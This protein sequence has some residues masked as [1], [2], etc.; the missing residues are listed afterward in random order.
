MPDY[1]PSIMDPEMVLE[2]LRN[3]L[4]FSEL[5]E[6][7][8]RELA[9]GCT[10]DFHPK[11]TLLYEQGVT[12]VSC[13]MLIQKGGVR[14]FTRD[15]QGKENLVDFRGEGD[16]LGGLAMLQGGRAK[17][18]ATTV[19]DTFFIRLSR[20][21]F[22]N[23]L[24]KRPQVAQFYSKVLSEQYVTK[25]FDSLRNRKELLLGESGLSL[26]RAQVGEMLHRP[27]VTA[28]MGR[29]IQEAAQL[30]VRHGIGSL[31]IT[32]PSGEILGIVTDKDLRKTISVG[33]DCNAP[34]ETIMSS[35]VQAVEHR[36]LCFDA[37]LQMMT[38]HIH[39]L[40][41]KREG[42]VIG[43]VTSHDIMVMQ[44]KSPMSL[45]RE[46]MTQR[47]FEGLYPLSGRIPQVVRSLV[48][49]GAKA[50][51]IAR[52]IT[53]INDMIV[54]KVL[55]LLLAQLGPP[56][57]P[58]CWLL[59]GSEGRKEQ[60]FFTD[61]DNA[62]VYRDPG[63]EILQRAADVYFQAFTE[64]ANGHLIK[65]GMPPCPGGIMASNPK[66]RQPFAVWR[67][68][69]ERWIAVNNPQE[70]M[71]AAIFFDFRPCF[72]E[73]AYAEE[74]RSHVTTHARRQDV[75]LRHL[76]AN[77]LETRPPLSFFRN[78]IVE[79]DGEHKN[80]LDIKT[81]GIAPL[82]DFIRVLAL[83]HG[84]RETNTLGRL[85]LLLQAQALPMELAK[86]TREA[87]E[88]MLQLRLVHQLETVERG[89]VPDNH[90]A[91]DSLSELERKTL[92]EAF[93]LIGRAQTHLKE[94][95]RMNIA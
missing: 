17:F 35:P 77:C 84:I 81:R 63:D 46:I 27:P 34:I 42:E 25:A 48:E 33:M 50:G 74:L 52:M 62:L 55:A 69:F 36:D 75:F 26:F 19:E 67:D 38:R 30:M 29:T 76:A 90:I 68:Y 10:I 41:V 39:H 57:V 58:F 89:G 93:A 5:S 95:F 64:R 15:D 16:A 6:A 8:R 71:H 32:D 37:L 31:L 87:Y 13:L 53:V 11:D 85:D 9:K 24:D 78:F 88:F 40:A 43:V 94:I 21:A 59:M 49:E 82:V 7:D 2:F 56:P 22:V 45:F 66:W 3:T 4:P 91:P 54:D 14:V 73:A 23:L 79:K 65:C 1:D 60:T 61:Q 83:Q 51:N 72:G 80:R 12:S 92:K 28:P 44:G 70:V 47:D 86:D 18:N 20:D